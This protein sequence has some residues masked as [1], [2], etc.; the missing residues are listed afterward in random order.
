[1]SGQQFHYSPS[2]ERSK[3]KLKVMTRMGGGA[4]GDDQHPLAASV[5]HVYL[6]PVGLQERAPETGHGV[7][8][9]ES[10]VGVTHGADTL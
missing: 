3:H 6:E 10:V 4:R 8:G 1:M 7:D 2:Q 5:D 9:Q